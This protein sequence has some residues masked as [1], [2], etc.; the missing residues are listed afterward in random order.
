MAVMSR[1]LSSHFRTYVGGLE[2]LQTA[3]ALQSDVLGV[4]DQV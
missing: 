4:A 3:V 2:K 1:I